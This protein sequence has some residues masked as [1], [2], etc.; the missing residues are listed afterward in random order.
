MHFNKYAISI[1]LNIC[2]ISFLRFPLHNTLYIIEEFRN[3]SGSG[4]NNY[5]WSNSETIEY[6]L[7]H[8]LPGNNYNLYSNEPEAVYAL[9]KL[10]TEYSP[11]KTFYNSPQLLNDEYNN[12]NILM[13][14]KNGC[15]IWF[16]N[17]NRNFL[18]TIDE[19]QKSIKMTEVA[20]LKDGEIYT[21]K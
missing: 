21:F 13:D 14:V 10:K 7:R 16:N 17:A 5:L 2:I 20:H 15:L 6:L 8:K 12:K 3:Q 1:L 18:Y 4:Y 11:A 9:T 19:L